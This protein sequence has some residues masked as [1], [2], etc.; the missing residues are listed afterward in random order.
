MSDSPPTEPLYWHCPHCEIAGDDGPFC[1]K[2]KKLAVRA[3]AEEIEKV[4]PRGVAWAGKAGVREGGAYLLTTDY[5]R[6]Y[7]FVV[8][9]EVGCLCLFTP[10]APCIRTFAP[11]EA[12][13]AFIASLPGGDPA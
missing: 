9:Y 1:P 6:D 10:V 11:D 8:A 3:T 7:D 5:H 12:A 13:G 4:A 2:C